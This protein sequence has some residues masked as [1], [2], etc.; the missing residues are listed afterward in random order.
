MHASCEK[1]Q[2]RISGHRVEVIRNRTTAASYNVGVD[3]WL[4]G[5]APTADDAVFMAMESVR[6]RTPYCDPPESSIEF[7][8]AVRAL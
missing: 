7:A 5:V 4:V 2:C 6:M 1:A 3:G 8:V